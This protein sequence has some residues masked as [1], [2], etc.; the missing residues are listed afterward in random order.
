M[1]QRWYRILAVSFIVLIAAG[2][3]AAF[4]PL[5]VGAP[6]DGGSAL[7]GSFQRS[8]ESRYDD[9][10]PGRRFSVN[11]WTAVELYLFGNGKRGVVV[12]TDGWLY[13]DEEFKAVNAAESNFTRNTEFIRKVASRMAEAGVPLLVALIPPKVD[14]YPEHLGRR[15]P[16]AIQRTLHK[17]TLEA[18]AVAGI[19]TVDLMATLKAGTAQG[20]VF[21][22]TDTHWTPYGARIG[23]AAVVDAIKQKGLTPS[24]EVQG[25][26]RMVEGEVRPHRGD[27]LNFL[28]LDPYFSSMLPPEDNLV[29]EKVDVPQ[30][31]VSSAS[32]GDLLFSDAAGPKV[33]LVGSSYSANPLWNFRGWIEAGLDE[34]VANYAKEAVGP[35][36][37]MAA[38]LQSDDFKNQKPRL[39]V[40]EMPARSMLA[41]PDLVVLQAVDVSVDN[42]P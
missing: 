28:P 40:W 30:P 2:G 16:A 26:Y 32:Q 27:L 42:T 1:E 35:F 24:G 25:D 15:K 33:A 13:T 19:A 34:A 23:A 4:K 36:A 17:R 5:L 22:R 39:V 20:Q 3:F 10:F 11:L 14:V 29:I 12:G 38:Y 8:L 6:S 31:S 37:P 21:F 18:L 7:D 9:A 41:D